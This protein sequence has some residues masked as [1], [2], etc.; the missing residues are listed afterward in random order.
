MKLARIPPTDLRFLLATLPRLEAEEAEI[1]SLLIEKKTDI[2]ASDCLPASWSHLYEHPFLEHV[3]RIAVFFVAGDTIRKC[4][5]AQRP[6]QAAEAYIQQLD[7][8]D[9]ELT[10][11]DKEN[12][13]PNLALVFGLVT[14]LLRSLQCLMAYGTYLNDLVAQVRQ[15]NRQG[16]DALFKAVK[17]DPSVMGAPSLNARISRAVLEDDQRFLSALKR[18]IN[19]P[20]SKQHQANSDKIRF[21]LQVLHESKVER[22]NDDELH[23]LFVQQLAL[24]S[25]PSKA[26]VGDA[27]K[28][29]RAIAGRMKKAKATT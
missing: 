3:A 15:G 17:I 19:G 13:R 27:A 28:G 2:F 1:R 11:E 7:D 12:I 18:A 24:Y 5:A 6:I 29:I 25:A 26:D 22:L 8:D 21:V 10:P 14:S 23:D 4:A 9:S 16:D 20:L